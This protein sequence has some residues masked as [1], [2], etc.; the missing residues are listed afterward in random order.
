MVL[1][2]KY[3]DGTIISVL[4]FLFKNLICLIAQTN[5]LSICWCL[6]VIYYIFKIKTNTSSVCSKSPSNYNSGFNYIFNSLEDKRWCCDI[7]FLNAFDKFL[8]IISSINW[9][10][11][12][13]VDKATVSPF[14]IE[15]YVIRTAELMQLVHNWHF[16]RFIFYKLSIWFYNV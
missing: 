2:Q 14:V 7:K 13:S 5:F 10:A 15:F 3:Q 11:Y 9:S 16:S 1:L 6:S 8:F 4:L 12:P